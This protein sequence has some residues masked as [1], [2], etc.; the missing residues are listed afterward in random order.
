MAY[1]QKKGA[2]LL[3]QPLDTQNEAMDLKSAIE[4]ASKIYEGPF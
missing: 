4:K 3:I 2:E 1:K